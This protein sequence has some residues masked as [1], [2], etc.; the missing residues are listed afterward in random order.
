MQAKNGVG[1]VFDYL[2]VIYFYE[3]PQSSMHPLKY[4]HLNAKLK[5]AIAKSD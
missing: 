2:F 4:S 5:A 3:N 1:F